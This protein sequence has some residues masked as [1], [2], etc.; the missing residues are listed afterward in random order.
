MPHYDVTPEHS[1]SSVSRSPLLGFAVAAG[2][3][4]CFTAEAV[5]LGPSAGSVGF[6]V[7]SAL[8]AVRIAVRH[9]PR[10]LRARR[11]ARRDQ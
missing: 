11:S 8:V 2:V 10:W 9:L 6:G 4:Y 3:A 5:G 1:G 7:L